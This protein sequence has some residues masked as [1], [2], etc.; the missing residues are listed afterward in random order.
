MKKIMFLGVGR[1]GCKIIYEMRQATKQSLIR[2]AIYLF[3]DCNSQ[4]LYR[5]RGYRN[6]LLDRC[7]NKFPSEVFDDVEHL[8]I[9]AGMSG[10][11]GSK[12]SVL[13]LAAAHSSSIKT[14]SMIGVIGF[15]CEG[16]GKVLRSISSLKKIRNMP[17]VSLSIY[18]MGRIIAKYGY[19]DVIS[20]LEKTDEE[21]INA[22]EGHVLIPTR[23]M[24]ARLYPDNRKKSLVK[25]IF[26]LINKLVSISSSHSANTL[27]PLI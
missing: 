20:A 9:V 12:F 23:S 8:I 24:S 13:A 25:K 15:I 7:S 26:S 27:G 18:N 14:L 2:N 21:I 11:T 3:A 4:D 1:Y 17:W 5:Y 22:I 16:K 10:Y 19:V 6:I